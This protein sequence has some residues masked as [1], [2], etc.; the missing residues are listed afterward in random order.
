MGRYVSEEAE[1]PSRHIFVPN[2]KECAKGQASHLG[3]VPLTRGG[4]RTPSADSL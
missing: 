1:L 2:G 3:A 4:S